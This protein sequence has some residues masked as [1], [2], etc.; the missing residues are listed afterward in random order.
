MSGIW[1]A[2]ITISVGALI[3]TN[4][5]LALASMIAGANESVKLAMSLCASYAFWLGFFSL[6]DKLGIAKIL[7]KILSPVIKFLF[8]SATRQSSE[9]IA[10]NVSANVIGLGN[11]STPMG[12]RAMSELE[13]DRPQCEKDSTSISHD[14][15]TFLVLS[16]TS[17]QILPTTVL[18][19]RATMGST[20]PTSIIFPCIVATVTSTIVGVGVCKIISAIKTRKQTKKIKNSTNVV[21]TKSSAR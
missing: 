8:P 10:L 11:A 16:S 17:L 13:K 1:W 5:A 4:P 2:L 12:I 21:S 3:I 20:D 18:G 14:M 6:I 9:F 19:L 15:L 7:A